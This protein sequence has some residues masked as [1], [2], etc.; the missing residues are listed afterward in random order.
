MFLE[1]SAKTAYHVEEAFINSAKLIL[2]NIE[3]NKVVVEDSK[4]LNLKSQK[5]GISEDAKCC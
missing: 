4:G 5:K 2:E 3:K 1:T